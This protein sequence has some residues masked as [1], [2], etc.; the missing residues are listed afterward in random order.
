MAVIKERLRRCGV[1]GDHDHPIWRVDTLLERINHPLTE[2]MKLSHGDIIIPIDD[3]RSDF[4]SANFV[5]GRAVPPETI[6]S[7]VDVHLPRLEDILG[8][9]RYPLRA[10]HLE[11]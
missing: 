6:D 4:V 9:G 2:K 10:I 7:P 8:H 1:A 5:T 11:R 3:S